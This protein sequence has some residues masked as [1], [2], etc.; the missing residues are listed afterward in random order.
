MQNPDSPAKF[1]R[2]CPTCSRPVGPGDKFCATCRTKIPVLLTCSKCGTQFTAPVKYCDLCGAPVI[3]GEVPEPVDSLKPSGEENTGPVDDSASE[4]DEE[5]IPEPDTEELPE[6]YE[7][8]TEEEGRVSGEVEI[9]H[10]YSREIQEPETEELLKQYGDG[11]GEDETLESYHAL[12]PH[13]PLHHEVKKPVDALSEQESSE[14]VDDALFFS[15]GKPKVTPKPRNIR[16]GVIAGCIVVI[17]IMAVVYFIGMPKFMEI[18][19]FSTP[20]NQTEAVI[21]PLPEPTPVRTIQTSPPSRA[22][23]PLP[24]QL[25]PSDQKL[26]F[27]VQKNPITAKISVVFAGS[28]GEGSIKIAEIK[29]SHPDG[30]FAT[31]IIQPLKGIN[32]ITLD[33]SKDT[34]RVEIIAQMSDGRTYR[35]YDDLVP[36]MR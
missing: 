13:P 30:S 22:L 23:V 20:K 24:T 18:G 28:A 36:L 27:Q 10:H 15:P 8:D 17:I 33:G 2:T 35:V 31:G 21:T 9:P 1:K 32:E 19:G 7:E 3:L 16:T 12:K 6:G 29:V 25:V 11:Y 5:E 4:P 14:V 26:Y 34:D